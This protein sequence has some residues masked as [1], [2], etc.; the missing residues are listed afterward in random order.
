MLNE[1]KKF[2]IRGNVIDLAVGIIIGT[3]F[4]A[5]V[6]SLV[7]DVLMPPLGL[8]IGGIDFSDFFV[9][10]KGGGHE[11]LAAAKAAGDVTINYGLF[12]NS[13]IKFIIVAFAVFL[14]V[15]YINKLAGPKDTAPPPPSKSEL[16]LAE[17][18]DLLKQRPV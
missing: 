8:I 10:L 9:T 14:L 6:T 13:I 1:F 5:I 11:T 16:L 7:N 3:A 18:R 2:A 12:L 17:I 15:R 4:T